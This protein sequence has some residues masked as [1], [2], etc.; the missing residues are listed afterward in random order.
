M[1]AARLFAK[2]AAM[3]LKRIAEE[4]EQAMQQQMALK[5]MA[6]QFIFLHKEHALAAENIFHP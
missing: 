4:L 2:E 1:M 3:L 5:H 6:E